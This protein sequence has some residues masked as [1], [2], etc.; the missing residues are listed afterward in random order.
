MTLVETVIALSI[1]LVIM[2]AVT[3]FEI[4]IF[5][6]QHSIS[7]SF[8]ASQSA[9]T[10]LK[11]MTKELRNMALPNNGSYPLVTAGTS[12]IVFSSDVNNDGTLDQ[13]SY[14]L[15]GNSLY[16]YD[17]VAGATTII[18]TNVVNDASLPLF[19]Y[20]DGNYDGSTGS[21]GQPLA[22]PVNLA[23]VRSTRVSLQFAADSSGSM[24]PI[25][26]SSFVQ[27]RNL[28]TNI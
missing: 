19:Q 16:K 1:F 9:Q 21:S 3:T 4:N 14:A 28:K 2:A 18:A 10:I 15:V 22:Q 26:Y 6:Y 17:S 11:I 25:S 7:G 20:F 8:N 24:T 13:V 27:L 5:S 23:V 12:T